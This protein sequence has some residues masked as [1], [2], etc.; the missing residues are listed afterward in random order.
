LNVATPMGR[1]VD[2]EMDLSS[3]VV[4]VGPHSG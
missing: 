4:L 1:L 3:L 2:R